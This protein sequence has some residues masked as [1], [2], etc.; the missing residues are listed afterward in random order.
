MG[1]PLTCS[2]RG[3]VGLARAEGNTQ[4]VPCPGMKVPWLFIDTNGS[5]GQTMLAGIPVLQ[6]GTLA[7]EVLQLDAVASP[8]CYLTTEALLPAALQA[9]KGELLSA[10]DE[11]GAVEVRGVWRL[12]DP[13]YMGTLLELVLVR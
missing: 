5:R 1:A 8:S 11:I 2:S 9:S 10:L 7:P 6:V 3:E 12:V 13:T 4:V